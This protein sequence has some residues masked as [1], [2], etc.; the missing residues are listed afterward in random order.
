MIGSYLRKQ[1]KNK[2]KLKKCNHKPTKV[3]G[4]DEQT[5]IQHYYKEKII[6][7]LDH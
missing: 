4:K 5:Q 7:K 1:T 6:I 3:L 2:I